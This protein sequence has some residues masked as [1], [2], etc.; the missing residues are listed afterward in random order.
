M[1]V[2][3]EAEVIVEE[4]DG[5]TQVSG[6]ATAATRLDTSPVTASKVGKR[7]N[8]KLGARPILTGYA[9]L[10]CRPQLPLV[11]VFIENIGEVTGLVDL[12]ASMSAIRLSVVGNVLDPK[13]EKSFLNLTGVDD[14]KVIVDSFCSLK[15]KWENKVVELNEVIVVKNRSFALILGV[16]WIVKSKLNLIV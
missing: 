11:R 2:V 9:H 7:T 6:N 13:R 3:E 15:V 1:I 10:P 8:R 14:K 16:D 12:G 4:E 5:L